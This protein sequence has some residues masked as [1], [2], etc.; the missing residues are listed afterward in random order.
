MA[1]EVHQIDYAPPTGR[2]TWWSRRTLFV[3]VLAVAAGLSTVIVAPRVLERGRLLSQ[4]DRLALAGETGKPLTDPDSRLNQTRIVDSGGYLYTGIRRATPDSEPRLLVVNR[5]DRG[6]I[7]LVDKPATWTSL[8][9]SLTARLVNP[10]VPW[11]LSPDV[12]FGKNDPTNPSRFTIPVH[13]K[14]EGTDAPGELLGHIVGHLLPN[15]TIRLDWE[16]MEHQQ[17]A[18]PVE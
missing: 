14:N 11:H 3:V 5:D 4:Q 2:P 1:D 6:T 15:D 16:P 8:R 12:L 13:G 9:E 10:P 18:N 17:P 7:V